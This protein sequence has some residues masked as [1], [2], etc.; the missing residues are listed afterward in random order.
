MSYKALENL[1][2]MVFA[3]SSQNTDEDFTG[4]MKISYSF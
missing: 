1:S 4:N 3:G 2:F